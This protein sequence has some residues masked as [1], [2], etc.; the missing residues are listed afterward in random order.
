MTT[1]STNKNIDVIRDNNVLMEYVGKNTNELKQML[2]KFMGESERRDSESAKMI[3][4]LTNE[5]NVL[6]E[7]Y[8]KTNILLDSMK[9]K[10]EKYEP[11]KRVSKKSRDDSTRVQCSCMTTKGTQCTR[12]VYGGETVC[13][14]HKRMQNKNDLNNKPVES[15][16]VES[17]DVVKDTKENSNVKKGGKRGKK[18]SLKKTKDPPPMH[19]H[20][21]GEK[22][23]HP[24]SLCES[25]GDIFDP[26]LPDHEFTG[27]V[28][29]G[30]TLEERLRI[31]I[32]EEEHES[33]LTSNTHTTTSVK[34][35]KKSWA[36]MADEDG[37]II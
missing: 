16:V 8:T 19:N 14:M 1:V 32:E 17:V 7:E 12:F 36:D 29:D 24:C 27:T 34:P 13:V 9:D 30:K 35:E 4:L 20:E 33:N 22:P 10:L 18:P 37:D 31:A 15:E 28:V 25:H 3:T 2:L 6:K 23:T 5:V 21:P 26:T 11:T